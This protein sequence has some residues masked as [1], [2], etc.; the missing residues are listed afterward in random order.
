MLERTKKNSLLTLL[1][2]LINDEMRTS[3]N[4]ISLFYLVL[5]VTILFWSVTAKAEKSAPINTPLIPVNSASNQIPF[6][7]GGKEDLTP[8]SW[9]IKLYKRYLSPVNSSR[10]PMYP[11]CSS[12]AAQALR[13]HREKGLIMAFDRLL[14][15]GRDLEDYTLLFKRGRFLHYD[16]VI[17]GFECN[18][19][20]SP[21]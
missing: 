6:A 20:E 18:T 9:M 12:F 2:R 17:K 5:S 4:C 7:E 14:R 19:D 8:F 13:Y 16:P 3:S 10:C 11:S 1:N 21:K 15:C